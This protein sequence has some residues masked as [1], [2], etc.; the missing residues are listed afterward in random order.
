MFLK[1]VPF[2]LHAIAIILWGLKFLQNFF[3]GFLCEIK[4]G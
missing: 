1:I 3:K 2:N 4:S